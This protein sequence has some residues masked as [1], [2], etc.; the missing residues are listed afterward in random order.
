MYGTVVNNHQTVYTF[1]LFFTE[2]EIHMMCTKIVLESHLNFL[3]KSLHGPSK[4]HP[5]VS[6]DD[7]KD[8]D[9]KYLE[10]FSVGVL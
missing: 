3:G 1:L 2:V 4:T 8:F 7:N 5:P 6:R 10:Y 9:L